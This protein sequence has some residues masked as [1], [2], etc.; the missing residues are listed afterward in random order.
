MDVS[1]VTVSS[2]AVTLGSRF[3]VSVKVAAP[4][5][6]P[7]R[8]TLT[9]FLGTRPSAS[10][11]LRKLGELPVE[12]L[13]RGRTS[14]KAFLRAP[15]KVSGRRQYLIACAGKTPAGDHCVPARTPLFVIAPARGGKNR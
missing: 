8:Q 11:H 4:A 3:A 13:R 9:Y 6:N 7:G 1:S 14:V 12:K 5:G 15:S 2:P 10:G